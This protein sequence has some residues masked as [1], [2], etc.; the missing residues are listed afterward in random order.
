M[1]A[2]KFVPFTSSIHPGFWTELTKVKLEVAGLNEEAVPILGTFTNS[3]PPGGALQP[4]LSVEWN[5]FDKEIETN[6]NHFSV[7]GSVTVK[8]TI[9]SFKSEDKAAFIKKGG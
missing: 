7:R 3:D 8:N 1:E 5:A 2:L 6:W 4:R 9:E